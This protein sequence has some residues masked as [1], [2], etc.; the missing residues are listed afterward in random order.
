[1]DDP[2]Q[3]GLIDGVQRAIARLLADLEKKTGCYVDGLQI[4]SLDV[5]QMTSD[6][7]QLLRSVRIDLRRA[8]GGG[9]MT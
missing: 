7:Q 4:D 1:M 3:R 6:R 9:W 8:P 5:T 2:K